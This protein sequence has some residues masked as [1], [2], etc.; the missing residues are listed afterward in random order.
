[1]HVE[2]IRSGGFAGI[3]VAGSFD[4]KQLLP[5]QGST[6]DKLIEGA[7][8]FDLP[9]KIKPISPVADRFEYRITIS[10]E[11]QTHSVNVS[12]AAIPDQLRPLVD[13]LTTLVIES[14]K[15]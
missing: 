13:Y 3:K 1:M 8:F 4:T 7:S 9:E 15:Q 6:V 11:Q 10:S 12:E 5:E 2:F 14:K